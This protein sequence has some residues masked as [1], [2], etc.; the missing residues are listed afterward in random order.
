MRASGFSFYRRK[1][2]SSLRKRLDTRR[3]QLF[4][5]TVTFCSNYC[6]F[7]LPCPLP[8]RD[9]LWI[10]SRIYSVC[11]VFHARMI[12]VADIKQTLWHVYPYPTA[13]LLITP[14]QHSRNININLA[15]ILL[16]I[17]LPLQYQHLLA[18]IFHTMPTIL[19]ILFLV[20]IL[21]HN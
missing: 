13:K 10:Y 4:S 14:Y 8:S 12:D 5:F 15:D 11:I 1:K 6:L 18:A 7:L 2:P 17:F 19:D 9:I 16:V 21:Y 3:L 20:H